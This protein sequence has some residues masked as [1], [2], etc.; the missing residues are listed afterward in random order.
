MYMYRMMVTSFT[1]KGAKKWWAFA[2]ANY[3]SKMDIFICRWELIFPQSNRKV[4]L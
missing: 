1:L 3:K 4:S 2:E